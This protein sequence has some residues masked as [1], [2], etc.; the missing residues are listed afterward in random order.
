[1]I[2]TVSSSSSSSSGRYVVV[3]LRVVV[4]YGLLVVVVVVVVVVVDGHQVDD[5]SGEV[6][7]QAVLLVDSVEDCV[8]VVLGFQLGQVVGSS[9]PAAMPFSP[10]VVITGA[11]GVTGSCGL[12]QL[13]GY[14]FGE[15]MR[16]NARLMELSSGNGSRQHKLLK[17]SK[18]TVHAAIPPNPEST[19][20]FAFSATDS[21]SS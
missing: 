5:C 19:T 21:T 1:M 16:L 4:V 10:T 2:S 14:G 12:T 7:H 11:T 6:C 18:S 8:V 3:V 17:S 9:A 20:Y 15:L 13:P